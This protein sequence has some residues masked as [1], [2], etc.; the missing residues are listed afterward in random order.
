LP[1][2]GK[3][4]EPFGESGGS[5]EALLLGKFGAG[6]LCLVDGNELNH[7]LNPASQGKQLT[8]QFF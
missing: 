4:S 3:C 7:P 5:G 8:F 6:V 1:P 2:V